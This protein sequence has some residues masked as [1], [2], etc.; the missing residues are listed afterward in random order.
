MKGKWIEFVEQL[1]GK[2][3]KTK[4]FGVVN[5]DTKAVIGIISWYGP[6]RKYSFFP[7]QNTVYETTC[8]KDII[9]FIESLMK[10][11]E[12]QKNSRLAEMQ[13]GTPLPEVIKLVTDQ[14]E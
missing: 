8:L 10:E 2:Y 5:K 6:F 4:I 7:S 11:R 12:L 14:T 3:R 13:N 1:S 9:A